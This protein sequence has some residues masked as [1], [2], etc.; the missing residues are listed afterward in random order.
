M[1]KMTQIGIDA[2]E[3]SYTLAG[4]S[5]DQK[6][7]FLNR[8][9]DLLESGI[10]VILEKNAEDVS[11][12]KDT[13]SPAMVDRLTLT[14]E[15]I[16]GIVSD[17]RN[18]SNLP[19]PVGEIFDKFEHKAGLHIC[20]QRVPVGV[21]AVIYESRPNVTIDSACLM[22]K[23]GNAAIL[24]GGKETIRTNLALLSSVRA[25]L[26]ETGL[27]V[28]AIQFI[29]SPDREL[30][31]E[32]LLM[33]EYID[34]LIPRGGAGLHEF[35]RKNSKIPVI[36]GGIGICHLFVD[37]T[38]DQEKSIK[39]I[40]NAKVQRPTVCNALDT[41]LIHRAVALEFIPKVCKALSKDG[42]RFIAD[43]DTAAI[44]KSLNLPDVV[45]EPAVEGDFDI[46][47]LSL[48]LGI[49]IVD[50]L[51]EAAE[52][53]RLHSTKHSDGILT[54]N[55]A[56][57]QKFVA[58]VNSACV[59][60]NASTRFTDGS[61]LGLGAEIAISTQPLHARGPM[62]LRELTTYKWVIQGNYQFRK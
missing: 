10:P 60:V 45:F 61:E 30:M 47:W 39:V 11:G 4:I 20:K 1:K 26:E 55:H 9:A 25:A 51:D 21:I 57:A 42:V 8:L 19:D 33:D 28:N 50:N 31:N 7:R 27:P 59:Y 5:A 54:E 37:E 40:Q 22:I 14:K 62:A 43:K 12:A 38:A 23:S 15:R 29:D 17:V 49:K 56:N 53:I 41:I 13:L 6:N 58:A 52:H 34:M 3:A 46:E 44:L 36:T 2:R 35:C 18:V 16:L 24:R 32:L 48:V